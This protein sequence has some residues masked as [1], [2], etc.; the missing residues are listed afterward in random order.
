M[1]DPNVE[2]VRSKLLERSQRGIAKYGTTTAR[3]D[4]SLVDWLRHLQE[5]LLD[6][7]VYI[8]AAIGR[9]EG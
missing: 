9:V 4:L 6:A 5:E 8:E 2:S 3:G 7:A 1:I